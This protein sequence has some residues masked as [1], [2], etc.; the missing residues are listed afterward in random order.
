MAARGRREEKDRGTLQVHPECSVL[1]IKAGQHW[2][3]ETQRQSLLINPPKLVKKEGCVLSWTS[4]AEC[5]ECCPN[6]T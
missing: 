1:K 2:N 4:P 3:W 5:T 6:L